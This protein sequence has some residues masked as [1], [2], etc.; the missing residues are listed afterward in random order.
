VLE[1]S[2]P[3]TVAAAIEVLRN[4]PALCARLGANG[5][6]RAEREF[7]PEVAAGRIEETLE[8]VIG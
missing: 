2:T 6:V 8:E 5:R 4:D 7:A 1:D 3:E